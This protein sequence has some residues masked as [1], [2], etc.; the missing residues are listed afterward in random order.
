MAAAATPPR[1]CRRDDRR[2]A[3]LGARGSAGARLAQRGRRAGRAG[4]LCRGDP[5]SSLPLGRGS[6]APPAPARPAGPD[7]PR[8]R[9]RRG[10][11][12]GGARPVRA[13]RAARRAKPVRR[14]RR[15]LGR[16][17]ERAHRLC[18]FRA[19]RDLAGMSDIAIGGRRAADGAFRPATMFLV[20]AVGILAFV[21]MLVL[22]AYAPDM[23]SGH[24]GGA[25]AL[26]NSATGYSGLVRLALATG[27]NPVIVRNEPMLATENL[28][29]LTPESGAVNLSKPLEMRLTKPVLVVLPKW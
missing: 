8:A 11:A 2:R 26:S 9:R 16:L 1:A 13:H 20:A 6:F 28:V 4:S 17:V 27:R 29:V 3:R 5:P 7:Q 10:R 24:N 23:R 14:P 15:R 18:R 25:H 19:A 22:G 12:A 21:A